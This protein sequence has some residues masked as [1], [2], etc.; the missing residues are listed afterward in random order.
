MLF[1]ELC[2]L[3]VSKTCVLLSIDHHGGYM[4]LSEELCSL[5]V[6]KTSVLLS[7]DKHGG[8]IKLSE[9]LSQVGSA[10]RGH[11]NPPMKARDK[12]LLLLSVSS[13]LLF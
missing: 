12:F 4:Q 5:P 6:S 9:E 2:S 8:H 11:R 13:S 10:N 1:E 7:I 3:P